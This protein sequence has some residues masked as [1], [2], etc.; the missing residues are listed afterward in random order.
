VTSSPHQ[1]VMQAVVPAAGR[2]LDVEIPVGFFPARAPLS[3][4]ARARAA[5]NAWV[6]IGRP[7][8]TIG[9]WW[10]YRMTIQADLEQIRAARG[11]TPPVPPAF[12]LCWTINQTCEMRHLMRL[13]VSGILTDFPALLRCLRHRQIRQ[14][15]RRRARGE[16][17][18]SVPPCA[19]GMPPS[20]LT[21]NVRRASPRRAGH[22]LRRGG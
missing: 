7:L 5:G 13:G 8:F 6:S 21:R 17:P 22:R 19:E 20:S 3:A 12:Y 15:A 16:T 9:G 2:S 11:T 4:G 1:F 10:T 18:G 14:D